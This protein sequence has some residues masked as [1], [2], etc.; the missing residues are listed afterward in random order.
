MAA[1][2]THWNARGP[3]WLDAH[4]LSEEAVAALDRVADEVAERLS[5]LGG[6]APVDTGAS[7]L[8]EFPREERD[9]AR[10]M[11]LLAQALRATSEVAREARGRAGPVDPPTAVLLDRACLRIEKAAWKLDSGGADAV[12][13]PR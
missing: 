2:H 8:A 13:S 5:Q 1:L 3:G 6:V 12:Q 4:D 10:L 7:A 11:S 9:P